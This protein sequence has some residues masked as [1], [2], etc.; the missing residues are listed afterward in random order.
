M[1][2][3]ALPVGFIE[4][5]LPTLARAVPSGPQ[6]A[7]EVKH[8]GFRFIARRDG[9]RVRVFGRNARDWTNRVPLIAEALRALPVEFA[10]RSI[11]TLG[12]SRLNVRVAFDN[13]H[14]ADIR[15][16]PSCAMNGLM[17]CSKS[18]PFSINL[19]AMPYRPGSHEPCGAA[20]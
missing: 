14:G 10:F 18:Q 1:L 2:S 3:P 8:D 5:C 11:S 13:G 20:E 16:R 12:L 9:D 17:R 6:W 4:P 7:F 15:E 19:A